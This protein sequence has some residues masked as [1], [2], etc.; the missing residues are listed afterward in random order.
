MKRQSMTLLF[1]FGTVIRYLQDASP[2]MLPKNKNGIVDN[3]KHLIKYLTDFELTVTTRLA[4]RLFADF[5][6]KIEEQADTVALTVEQTNYIKSNMDTLR[7]TLEAELQDIYVYTTTPKVINIDLLMSNPAGLFAPGVF[8][9]LPEIARYDLSEAGKCI[10]FNLPTSASF[11]ILRGTESVLRF[12][13][14]TMVR[15]DRISSD[16]WGP[17]VIDLRAKRKTSKYDILNNHLDHI[18][19]S[20]RNPTQHPDKI[21]DIHECQDLWSLCVEVINR[22]IKILNEHG[23]INL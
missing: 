19:K 20:F 10:G 23:Y 4:H 22:M 3:F 14:Q 15:K 9:G 21:Y 12:Y 13:Y 1:S 17:I 2:G 5:F 16:M 8:N 11:H 7:K 18:R 6:K